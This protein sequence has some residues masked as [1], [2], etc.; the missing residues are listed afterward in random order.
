MNLS[1]KT[2]YSLR[3][4]L[5]LATYEGELIPVTRVAAAFGI[6]ANHLTK[7]SQSLARLHLL[8]M[9]R[10]RGGGIRLAVHPSAINLAK[11]IR[12]IE[13]S[14]VLVECF[15][16]KT[17]TCVI[18]P[19]CNLKPILKEARDAFFAVL[20]KYSLS[21]LLGNAALLREILNRTE[22]PPA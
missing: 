22:Q 13:G 6:S 11:V 3:L 1:L 15:D 4:L 14:I 19:I 17:N 12:E 5:F 20:A 7:V 10:G 8:E 9:V 16:R 2:D 18:A 21:D